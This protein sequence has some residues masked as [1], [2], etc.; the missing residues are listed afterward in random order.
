METLLFAVLSAVA[1]SSFLYALLDASFGEA[2]IERQKVQERVEH[3]LVRANVSK[4]IARRA[5]FSNIAI[6]NRMFKRK[7]I[8]QNIGQ[9]L[10]IGG[11]SI[12]VSVFL[13]SI[14]LWGG[15]VFLLVSGITK[16][17]TW[18]LG[19]AVLMSAVPYF[20]LVI[21]KKLY[22]AKFTQNLPD[23]LVMMRNSL[24]AGQGIQAAFKIIADEGP[25]PIN[26]EFSQMVRE[27]ELG[28]QMN[29]ALSSLYRRISTT[30]LRIFIIGTFI[31]QEVGGNMAELFHGIE[32][33]IRERI[34]Q[35]REMKALTAQGKISG[36]VLIGLP[37][38]LGLMLMALN[39]T[40]FEPLT[41]EEMGRNAL[42]FA[43]TMQAIGTLIIWKM[44][45]R[46]VVG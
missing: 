45:N 21:K 39:P 10:A 9:L 2:G 12:P 36:L 43:F 24:L 27:I 7:R 13:F 20:F 31:Q 22:I 3:L 17:Q 38:G 34:T 35:V 16:S 37:V 26:R 25:Y 40:Y 41:K 19:I 6:I 11:W 15:M 18:A 23:A 14:A 8:A 30:D 44:T 5:E 29:E 42:R 4:E 33:T 1:I 28:S 46:S 32:K